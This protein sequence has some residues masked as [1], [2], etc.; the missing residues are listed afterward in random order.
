MARRPI[1]YDQMHLLEVD[2]KNQLYWGGK[3]VVLEQRLT[4]GI[5][6]RWVAGIAAVSTVVAAFFP[7]A[8]HFHWFG[9]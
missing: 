3:A 5:V 9:W 8:I 7:M 6:E 4:L 2:D 1:S